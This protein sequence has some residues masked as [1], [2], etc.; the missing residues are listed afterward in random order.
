M[1]SVSEICKNKKSKE[2]KARDNSF[3]G[4]YLPSLLLIAILM[5]L[6]IHD[7]KKWNRMEAILYLVITIILVSSSSTLSTK[8]PAS[9]LLVSWLS[10]EWILVTYY[11]WLN[12][13]NSFHT[14]FSN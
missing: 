12:V 14:I 3:V 2:E 7:S 8:Y 4:K 13:K 10:I 11:N 6:W 1:D 9:S 5:M